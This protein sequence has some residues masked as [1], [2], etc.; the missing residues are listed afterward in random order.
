[1]QKSADYDT[2]AGGEREKTEGD[3]FALDNKDTLH[4][5]ENTSY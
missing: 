4:L 2:T 3:I 1:M 5:W